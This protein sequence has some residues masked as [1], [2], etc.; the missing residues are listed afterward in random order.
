MSVALQAEYEKLLKQ[1]EQYRHEYYVLDSP[2]ISDAVYDSLFRRLEELERQ[3]PELVTPT[4]PT[5]RVGENPSKKFAKVTH[6]TAMLSLTDAFNE[7]EVRSWQERI[8]K[9]DR[10]VLDAK[11]F[12]ELKMDGLACSLIYV[13][14]VLVRAAT[15]G[16]GSVGEDV[17]ANIRTI[18][19]VPLKLRSLVKGF[20]E[21][22]GEVY[23]PYVSFEKVNKVR[24]K[25][26]EPLFANPRNA[27]A[28]ALRQLDPKLT[29]SRNLQFMAYQLFAE[30]ALKAHHLEHEKLEQLG[31]PANVKNTTLANSLEEV[32]VYMKKV[33]K[34]RSR[35][36]YMIDGIV[37]QVD[38]NDLSQSLGIVGRAARSAVAFKFAPQEVTTKLLDIVVQVGRTGTLTPVAI[39]EPVNVMGVTVS[40]AT[41]HNEDEINRKDVRIGD[42]VVVRR[43]GDVIPEIVKPITELRSGKEKRYQFPSTCPICGSNVIRKD[44]EVA[45]RCSNAK[46][47]GQSH[48]GLRHFTSK[49]ALD[50]T[51]V[52]PKVIDA[53]HEAGLVSQP[54]DLFKLKE[55][56]L[57]VLP[58]FGELSA[59][60]IVTAIN[61][62][63]KI[64]LNRFVYALGI[65]NVGE[66]TARDLAENFVTLERFRKSDLT[67]LQAIKDIGGVVAKSIDDFLSSTQGKEQLE[68]LLQEIE[69]LPYAT[70]KRVGKLSGQSLVVTGTLSS[71]SRTQAQEAARN[72]GAQVHDQ[73]TAKTDYLV[74]G[75]NPGSNKEKAE[76]LGVKI[77]TEKEFEELIN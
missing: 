3:N 35:L 31:F 29:A 19:S 37:V 65:R 51:G 25:E 60:N 72:A 17:T 76:K 58:R 53:L 75:N 46:C 34:D 68:A 6:R 70:T 33:E 39:L 28:G 44:G 9:L 62:R 73:V 54:A 14:G 50:I 32:F 74:V 66:E 7:D 8:V 5:Q 63:R 2:S 23:M 27:A 26:G 64:P 12:C 49:A 71:M 45:Y 18:S 56:D 42:T 10:R 16:D 20:L 41:L 40:R 38:D 48:L 69:V 55:G 36:P 15:R 47:Y 30:P 57:A 24:E 13:D 11:Y 22:R 4:S 52:G 1:I 67:D 59:K 61:A 21:V 43:A 77:L